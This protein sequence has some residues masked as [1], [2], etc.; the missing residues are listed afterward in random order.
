MPK[1]KCNYCGAPISSNLGTCPYCDMPSNGSNKLK[2][3]FKRKNIKAW[4]LKNRNQINNKLVQPGIILLKNQKIISNDQ[5]KFLEEFIKKIFSKK[6]NLIILLSIPIGFHLYMRV[7]YPTT[8]KPYYPK[9]PFKMPIPEETG[10]FTLYATNNTKE[11]LAFSKYNCKDKLETQTL[12]DCLSKSHGHLKYYI[13][14]GSVKKEENWLVYKEAFSYKDNE[15]ST[16]VYDVAINC[17]EGLVADYQTKPISEFNYLKSQYPSQF[18]YEEEQQ[19]MRR[20]PITIYRKMGKLWWVSGNINED[21]EEGR[22]LSWYKS[23][24]EK[25]K[26][27]LSEKLKNKKPSKKE[28]ESIN[29]ARWLLDYSKEN[30]TY[31]Q[32][33][34]KAERKK[35]TNLFKKVCQS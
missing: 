10:N 18:G 34:R 24:I 20:K 35:Y 32:F 1:Y 7:N 14:L 30:L 6:R 17:K 22:Y 13:D 31:Q 16:S 9:F 21:L 4:L 19:F 5:I 15:P 12:L 3:L 27:V 2:R 23:R 25:D 26:K 28:L 11:Y 29:S 8:S 33:K